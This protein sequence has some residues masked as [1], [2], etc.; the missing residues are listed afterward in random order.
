MSPALLAKWCCTNPTDTPAA[1]ATVRSEVAAVPCIAK[2]L[3]A[4]FRIRSILE[5]SSAVIRSSSGSTD[6]IHTHL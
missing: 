1:S 2:L 5:P 4:A 3:N 6:I